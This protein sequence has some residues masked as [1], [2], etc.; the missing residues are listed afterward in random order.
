MIQIVVN[1]LGG[2]VEG[3]GFTFLSIA[4]MSDSILS[5]SYSCTYVQYCHY[6]IVPTGSLVDFRRDSL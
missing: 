4:C 6:S 5:Y 3:M 1:M 2:S